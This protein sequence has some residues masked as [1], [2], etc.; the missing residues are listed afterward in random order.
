M[1]IAE[2]VRERFGDDK[3]WSS[4]QMDLYEECLQHRVRI[5]M[6]GETW[7][8]EFSDGSAIVTTSQDWSIELPKGDTK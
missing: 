1:T 6:N 8:Y 5:K 7:R 3:F 2:K 4:R